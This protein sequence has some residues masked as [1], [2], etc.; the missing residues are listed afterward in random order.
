MT[1]EIF[2]DVI[3]GINFSAGLVRMDLTSRDSDGN[4]E[5]RQ[6]LVMPIQGFLAALT[7]MTALA[8]KLTAGL[9]QPSPA[10]SADAPSPQ[11]PNF[12]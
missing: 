8:E 12:R 2:M 11:S 7:T 9:P 3:G 10:V 6:R 1:A 4:A 5:V